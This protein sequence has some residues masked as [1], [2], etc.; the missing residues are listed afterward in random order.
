LFC[1]FSCFFHPH[2]PPPPPFFFLFLHTHPFSTL[3]SFIPPFVF[4]ILF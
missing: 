4:L 3:S 2:S 1:L